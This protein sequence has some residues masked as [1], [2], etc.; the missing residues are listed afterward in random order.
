MTNGTRRA[1]T[2]TL[3]GR[4]VLLLV[5]RT[6]LLHEDLTHS[7]IGAFYEV[8]RNLGY[9]FLE[10]HYVSA[11]ERELLAK[12]HRVAREFAVLV[13]YKGEELG[14][15]RLDLVVD[16]LL[17][18]EVKSTHALPAAAQRQL[19]NYLKATNLEVGLLLHFGPEGARFHRQIH[20]RDR[21]SF[22][23]SGSS[24]DSG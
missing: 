7:V 13:H 20:S 23:N 24:A 19:Y 12:G 5:M 15:H 3:R 6:A 10:T 1:K 2:I 11:L 8:Q 14:Y 4:L 17:V 9:G 21:K 22:V 18:V 16:D